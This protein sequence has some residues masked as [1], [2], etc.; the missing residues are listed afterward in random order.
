[1][2]TCS[3]YVGSPSHAGTVGCHLPH[4][5][6]FSS[7]NLPSLLSTLTIAFLPHPSTSSLSLLP[8]SVGCHYISRFLGRYPSAVSI[9]WI[10]RF[11]REPSVSHTHLCCLGPQCKREIVVRI[12]LLPLQHLLTCVDSRA[13][14]RWPM[15]HIPSQS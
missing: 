4:P 3:I 8:L 11:S 10:S 2:I 5:A 12:Q 9:F 6:S 14:N 13:I 7:Q 1:M 15:R